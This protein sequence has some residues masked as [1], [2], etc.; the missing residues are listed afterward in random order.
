MKIKIFSILYT[1]LSMSFLIVLSLFKGTENL[2]IGFLAYGFIVFT[3]Y[4]ILIF[5]E[6][7]F[8][9]FIATHS[10]LNYVILILGVFYYF[11]ISILLVKDI[12][13]ISFGYFVLTGCASSCFYTF[14]MCKKYIDE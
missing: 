6:M 5:K 4:K 12:I 9:K 8:L 2:F 1:V 13:K 14:L 3:Q 7:T 11:I 10:F